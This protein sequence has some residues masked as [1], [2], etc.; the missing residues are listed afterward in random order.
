[1]RQ[2]TAILF[3]DHLL[4]HREET[5]MKGIAK[6]SLALL[7]VLLCTLSVWTVMP[8]TTASAATTAKTTDY[9]NLRKGPGTSY[10]V[11]VTMTKGATITV[12]DNS[13]ED[14]AKVQTSSGQQGWCSKEYLQISSGSSSSAETAKTTDYLNLR[15]GAGT[16]Y[17]VILTIAKGTT[18]TVLDNS[19]SN[20]AKVRTPSGQE[21]WCSKEYLTFSSSGS[22]SSGGSSSGSTSTTTAKTTDYLNLRKGAG[23]SYGVILT[24]AKGST[25]TVLDNSNKE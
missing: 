12:L 25:V 1:M 8:N 11:I 10:G 3:A 17:G 14:W 4:S 22:S 20:W 24:I 6:K 21:G 16:S 13:D 5:K 2:N 15:K 19:N 7:L 18:V 9:L 23:T